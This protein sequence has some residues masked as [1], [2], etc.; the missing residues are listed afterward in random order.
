MDILFTWIGNKDLGASQGEKEAGLG[1]IGQAVQSRSFGRVILLSDYPLQSSKIFVKWLSDKSNAKIDLKNAK[2]TRPTAYGEIYEKASE[3]VQ[4]II[5]SEAQKCNIVFHLS[6]GTPAMQAMWILLAKSRFFPDAELIE[7]S[8]ERG[9][10]TTVIPFDISADYIRQ[11]DNDLIKLADGLDPVAQQFDSIIHRSMKMKRLILQ[12]Q[13]VATR[14][15]PVLLQGESGTGKELMALAIH[16]SSLRKN[17]KF[18]PINCG[19]IPKEL[20]ESELFGH[21]KGAFTS[22]VS[23]RVGLIEESSGGTLFLDEI[24]DLPLDIQVKLLR[25]LQEEKVRP[26]GDNKHIE[27]DLRVIAATNK[28][29]LKEVV[30]GSFRED[31]Y[32]RLAV[33]IFD[34]PP[35]RERTE[36]IGLI[37]DHII[38]N[39]NKEAENQPGYENKTL[40]ASAKRFIKTYSWPGN[41]RELFNTLF[42]SAIW[43]PGTILDEKIIKASLLKYPSKTS[44]ELFDQ[45]F[46]D[47]FKIQNVIESTVQHFIQK[48]LK[49]SGG[50][51]TKAANLLG[52]PNYQTLS[53]WMIKYKVKY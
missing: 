2:L 16:Q 26:M 22:A 12:A 10:S 25:V 45:S 49:E 32:H 11:P 34:L 30:E 31:L 4:K 13:K 38:K 39:I 1:P 5:K 18:V 6:P 23:N 51:K 37:A 24:G 43:T 9:L 17:R 36:D 46:G 19:A 7:T 40:S 20:V 14:N 47:G 50:S 3:V 48:A 42:R 28:N 44:N 41:V 29:L 27:V 35:L 8:K 53:N 15:V 33:I 21:K 52:L